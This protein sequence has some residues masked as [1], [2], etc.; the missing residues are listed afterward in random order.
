[1]VHSLEGWDRVVTSAFQQSSER[2]VAEVFRVL[3]RSLGI[4]S[5]VRG[6]SARRWLDSR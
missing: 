1:M 5:K 2:A 6:N 3:I 4:E